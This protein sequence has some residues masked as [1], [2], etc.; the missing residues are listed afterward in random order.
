MTDNSN[1]H[2]I[3][4]YFN[5]TDLTGKPS[6][7]DITEEIQI[8]FK[9]FYLQKSLVISEST[10]SNGFF[11]DTLILQQQS[12]E[13][14]LSLTQSIISTF[15]LLNNYSRTVYQLIFGY[16]KD[17]VERNINVL[18]I[19][20]LENHINFIIRNYCLSDEELCIVNNNSKM[21]LKIYNY[22]KYFCAIKIV[23]KLFS[24]FKL[25]SSINS[26]VLDLNLDAVSE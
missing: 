12:W 11:K 15:E 23:E 1:A 13:K 2:I 3:N 14:L 6:I 25:Q 5:D 26:F 19:G 8:E 20:S 24:F 16:C 10:E 21:A 17:N 9:T 7:L 4:G 18:D 22:V